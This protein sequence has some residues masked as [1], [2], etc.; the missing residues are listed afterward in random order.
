[1]MLLAAKRQRYF[2]VTNI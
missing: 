1:M 2:D